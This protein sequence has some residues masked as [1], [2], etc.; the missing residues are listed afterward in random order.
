MSWVLFVFGRSLEL[1]AGGTI[2]FLAS[3]LGQTAAFAHRELFTAPN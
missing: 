1:A 3:L 2:V